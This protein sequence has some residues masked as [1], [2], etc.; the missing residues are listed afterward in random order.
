MKR[1][2]DEEME[3]ENPKRRRIEVVVNIDAEFS[4]FQVFSTEVFQKLRK[5][6][7]D[8]PDNLLHDEATKMMFAAVEDRE[9]IMEDLSRMDH[10]YKVVN[11]ESLFE[12][13]FQPQMKRIQDNRKR[14]Q[15]EKR[16][17]YY[18]SLFEKIYKPQMKSIHENRK[19]IQEEKRRLYYE[20]LFEKIFQPQMKS[21][22]ENRKRIQEEK[23]RSDY[24]SLLGD[25]LPDRDGENA[26]RRPGQ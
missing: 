10:E 6:F 21:I 3:G 16:R 19:R 18:E 4:S 24:E 1:T 23:R 7:E 25:L 12:K 2:N 9:K 13:I 11:Y 15:E 26:A 5:Q 20:S 8:I 22:N 14:I 17:L